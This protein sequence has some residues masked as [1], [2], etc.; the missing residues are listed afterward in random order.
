MLGSKHLHLIR[1]LNDKVYKASTILIPH[2]GAAAS[3]IMLQVPRKILV[4]RSQRWQ[5]CGGR[6]HKAG[7][8]A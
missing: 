7:N 4:I 6:S 8:R 1:H 2:L 5:M 3:L